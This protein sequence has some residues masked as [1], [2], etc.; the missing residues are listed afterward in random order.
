[1]DDA[2]IEGGDRSTRERDSWPQV[3]MLRWRVDGR[4]GVMSNKS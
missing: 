3:S 2:L 4:P 1:M